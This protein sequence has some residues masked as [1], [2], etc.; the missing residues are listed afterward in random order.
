MARRALPGIPTGSMADIAFLLLVFW[1]MTTTLDVDSGILRRLPPIDT[2]Q[3]SEVVKKRNIY[4]VLV[5]FRNELLV[6]GEFANISELKKGAM[7]FMTNTGVFTEEVGEEDLTS[8]TWVR[9]AFVEEKVNTFNAEV[10]R[11]ED[12][13]DEEEKLKSVKKVRDNWQ[14]K[15]DA[16]N[17]FG[18]YRELVPAAVISIQNDKGTSYETYIEVQNELAS[19]LGQLRDDLCQK[20]W[21]L[22]YT[23]L[24][25][26]LEADQ[27][28]IKAVRNVFPNRISEA[29]PKDSR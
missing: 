5:N 26:K 14:S 4:E 23:E 22:N 21:K 7:E 13:G 29:E 15:L 28:R 11:L 8:R 27:I 18:E 12:K 10:K 19:A 6:E 2:E 20:H 17:F 25:E 9:R 3:D 16:I 24:D 1:L